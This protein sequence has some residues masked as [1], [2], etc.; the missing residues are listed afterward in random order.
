MKSKPI[1]PFATVQDFLSVTSA[2]HLASYVKSPFKDRGGLFLVG[3]PG[4][5]KSTIVEYLDTSFPDALVLSDINVQTLTRIKERIAGGSIRSLVMSDMEKLYERHAS[6]ASGIEGTLR[7][8][9]AEGFASASFEDV[10]ISR[11]K[12]HATVIGAMTGSLRERHAVRWDSSGFA[13]RFLWSLMHLQ[14]AGQ[15]ERAV[16]DGALIDIAVVDSPRAPASGGIPDLTTREERVVIAGWCKYQPMPNNIQI[17]LMARTWAVLKWW[18]TQ[19]QS[20][21]KRRTTAVELAWG[22][23]GRFSRSLG[24]DGV[25]VIVE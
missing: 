4:A 14:D 8:L 24:K 16:I 13:R 1:A 5:L 7:A 2:I 17:S 21:D 20:R 23:L 9:V 18:A 12:A 15:L 19:Q 3:P 25:E 10:T 6:V 22:T 11:L